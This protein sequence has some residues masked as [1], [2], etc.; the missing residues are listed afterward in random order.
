MRGRS[1]LLM[2]VLCLFGLGIAERAAEAGYDLGPDIVAIPTDSQPIADVAPG[3][4]VSYAFNETFSGT[5]STTNPTQLF[6]RSF[7]NY[8]IG[9]GANVLTYFLTGHANNG[10]TDV[11][12]SLTTFSAVTNA[13]GGFVGFLGVNSS[14]GFSMP[15][16]VRPWLRTSSI[17]PM[18]RP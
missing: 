5:A 17:R 10:V 7:H 9:T 18:G 3:Q 8:Y 15:W 1:R 4:T 13:S 2:G 12:F 16:S 11:S 6:L 14:G